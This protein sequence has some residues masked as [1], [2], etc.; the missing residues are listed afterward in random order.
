MSCDNEKMP[1]K[2]LFIVQ[3]FLRVFSCP[4]WPQIASGQFLVKVTHDDD[5]SPS[6]GPDAT[7]RAHPAVWREPEV[8]HPVTKTAQC[9]PEAAKNE[10]SCWKFP[11]PHKMSSESTSALPHYLY[12]LQRAAVQQI[13]SPQTTEIVLKG[14]SQFTEFWPSGF[15]CQSEVHCATMWQTWLVYSL[16]G[17]NHCVETRKLHHAPKLDPRWCG[18]RQGCE[19]ASADKNMNWFWSEVL[20]YC[21]GLFGWLH[22]MLR[23]ISAEPIPHRAVHAGPECSDWTGPTCMLLIRRG[24]LRH[25]VTD[26]TS[27]RRL[28]GLYCVWRLITAEQVNTVPAPC[29]ITQTHSLSCRIPMDQSLTERPERIQSSPEWDQ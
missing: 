5:H 2:P 24:T 10:I 11:F 27:F 7:H 12:S 6:L 21:D 3:S 29:I 14:K 20:P 22:C 26:L 23:L 13:S 25:I 4:R 9:W 28:F 18:L 15:L 1:E 16:F 17:L 19:S 8:N